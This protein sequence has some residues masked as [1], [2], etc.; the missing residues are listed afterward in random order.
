VGLNF[1][2]ML[3]CKRLLFAVSKIISKTIDPSARRHKEFWSLNQT[4]QSQT[5]R[6]VEAISVDTLETWKE[7]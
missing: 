2:Y 3:K 5:V 4:Q 1:L 7:L 6:H